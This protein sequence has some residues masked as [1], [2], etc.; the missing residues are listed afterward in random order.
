MA[1][2]K[3]P[4]TAYRNLTPKS[5]QS[6]VQPQT[7]ELPAMT[8][9]ALLEDLARTVKAGFSEM[10][11]D[12]QLVSSDLQVVKDR[13]VILEKAKI[14][15]EERQSRT[16]QGVR[17]SNEGFSKHETVIAQLSSKVDALNEKQDAQTQMLATNT[18]DTKQIL[19]REAKGFLERN[20]KIG[21]AFVA[22]IIVALTSAGILVERL[23]R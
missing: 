19:L 13:V 6:P 10:R 5:V 23:V 1:D 4:D 16:S 12:V 22:F 15:S 8:D 11:A 7:R 18:A 3:K 9:R 2:E 17:Q 14:E 21:Q 20:P